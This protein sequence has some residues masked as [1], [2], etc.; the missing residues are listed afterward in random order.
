MSLREVFSDWNKRKKKSRQ[1]M[2]D[3]PWANFSHKTWPDEVCMRCNKK[4]DKNGN[5]IREDDL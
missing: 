3:C 2:V 4:V 1:K 5:P